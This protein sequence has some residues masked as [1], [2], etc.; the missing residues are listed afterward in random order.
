MKI[1]IGGGLEGFFELFYF[2]IFRIAFT[3][4]F[5]L[6]T[7]FL[8]PK[9]SPPSFYDKNKKYYNLGDLHDFLILENL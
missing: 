5:F 9:P 4:I 1:P 8:N 6:Y 3:Q 2:F 7:D